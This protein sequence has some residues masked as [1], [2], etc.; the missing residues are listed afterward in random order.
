MR[1]F[2]IITSKKVSRKPKKD[3]WINWEKLIDRVFWKVI[4]SLRNTLEERFSPVRR[5]RSF[6]PKYDE[7]LKQLSLGTEVAGVLNICLATCFKI[8]NVCP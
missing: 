7:I 6:L 2:E 4:L 1:P 8:E 5:T 3:N